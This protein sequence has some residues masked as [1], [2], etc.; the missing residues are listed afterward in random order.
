MG[1]TNLNKIILIEQFRPSPSERTIEFPSEILKISLKC[2]KK[3]LIEET[4]FVSKKLSLGKGT[5]DLRE[6]LINYFLVLIAS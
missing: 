4:G 6:K 3:E 2:S 5:L 1:I